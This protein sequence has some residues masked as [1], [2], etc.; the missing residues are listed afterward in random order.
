MTWPQWWQASR[1]DQPM[2]D[3]PGGAVGALEAV[4]AM[5]AQGQR[6]IA[7]TVEEEQGLLAAFE[8]GLHLADQGG[9]QPAAAHGRI[10]EE[11]DGGDVGH[12]RRAIATGELHLLIDADLGHVPRLDARGWRRRG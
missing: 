1:L 8:I 7:A 11:V 5:A 4:A 2:L 9:R 3:H 10:G 6:R 12:L